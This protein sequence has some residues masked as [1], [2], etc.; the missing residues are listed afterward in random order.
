MSIN[1]SIT[2]LPPCRRLKRT[3]LLIL[4]SM[5]NPVSTYLIFQ[6]KRVPTCL[7]PRRC[8]RI[9]VP[10]KRI[11]V[12]TMTMMAFPS[13]WYY[14]FARPWCS[15]KLKRKLVKTTMFA[16]KMRSSNWISIYWV[17]TVECQS[18]SNSS[19]RRRC[20]TWPRLNSIS[21]ASISWTSTKSWR[22]HFW[23][24][25]RRNKLRTII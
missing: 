21:N 22:V 17:K 9:L 3:R 2:Q 19:M 14:K 11:T 8:K 18:N 12:F 23:I 10:T 4:T 16:S 25:S 20:G 24:I 1:H 6:S 15:L 13:G 7:R 5:I